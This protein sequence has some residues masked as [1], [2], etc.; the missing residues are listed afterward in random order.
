M[1]DVDSTS[2]HSRI[3]KKVEA[4]GAIWQFQF[5]PLQVRFLGG[6][7]WLMVI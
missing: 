1:T 3:A 4:P 7:I 6:K 2:R 5:V